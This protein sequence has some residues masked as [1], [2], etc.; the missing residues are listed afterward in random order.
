[1]NYAY[2]VKVSS[3]CPFLWTRHSVLYSLAHQFNRTSSRLLWQAFRHAV[4]DAWRQFCSKNIHHSLQLHIHSYSWVNWS[5]E[6]WTKFQMLAIPECMVQ[7]QVLLVDNPKLQPLCHCA[8]VPLYL[9][10]KTYHYKG[11]TIVWIYINWYYM[12]CNSRF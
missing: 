2:N 9:N 6:E 4:I 11:C 7:T 3:Q 10:V 8:T 1:M 12:I 5:N